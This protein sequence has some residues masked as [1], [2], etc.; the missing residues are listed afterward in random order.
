MLITLDSGVGIDSGSDSGSDCESDSESNSGA[1]SGGESADAVG[2]P[3]DVAAAE[4]AAP[5]TGSFS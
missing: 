2:S 1:V 3:I 4:V 5:S